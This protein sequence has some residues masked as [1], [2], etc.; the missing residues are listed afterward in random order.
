MRN[1]FNPSHPGTV[2]EG[3]ACTLG[4]AAE[5]WCESTAEARKQVDSARSAENK[6]VPLGS[7]AAGGGAGSCTSAT[8]RSPPR[9]ERG[10][11]P[12]PGA[13]TPAQQHSAQHIV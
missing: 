12:A 11:A 5:A 1:I 7:P 3:R 10:G 4:T 13:H 8:V 6:L 9:R 2:I